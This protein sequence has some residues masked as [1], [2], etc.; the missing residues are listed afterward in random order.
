M[1][2]VIRYRTAFLAVVVTAGGSSGSSVP[3]AGF[4]AGFAAGADFS[5]SFAKKNLPSL[6]T[7][8]TCTL[9]ESRSAIIF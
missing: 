1:P 5:T 2:S 4:G 8:I 9:S 6:G 3:S 7:I